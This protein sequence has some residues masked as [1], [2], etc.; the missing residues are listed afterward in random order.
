MLRKCP[1]RF[2]SVILV[3]F[4]V[5]VADFSVIDRQGKRNGLGHHCKYKTDMKNQI[6]SFF[7]DSLGPVLDLRAANNF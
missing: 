4:S 7:I 6:Q 3:D 5:I 1:F 2:P